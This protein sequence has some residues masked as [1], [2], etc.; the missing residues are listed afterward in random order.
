MKFRIYEYFFQEMDTISRYDND[1]WSGMFRYLPIPITDMYSV[2]I[3]SERRVTICQTGL[4][5]TAPR[6]EGMIP[7]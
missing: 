5:I 6:P 7:L 1:V 4:I 3:F 2:S